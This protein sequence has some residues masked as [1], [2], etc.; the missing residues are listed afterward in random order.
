M[1]T[2]MSRLTRWVTVLVP[3]AT[4]VPCYADVNGDQTVDVQ[5]MTEL[6]LNWGAC[7]GCPSDVNGDGVVNVSDLTDLILAWGP[8]DG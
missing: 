1:V 8:C 4:V 6:I 7:P 5:D 3:G 2:V